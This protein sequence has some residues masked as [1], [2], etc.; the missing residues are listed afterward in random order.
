MCLLG[1]ETRAGSES[2]TVIPSDTEVGAASSWKE[3]GRGELATKPRDGKG[4]PESQSKLEGCY[5]TNFISI[6]TSGL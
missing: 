2:L 4:S 1:L 6:S 5:N 3:T